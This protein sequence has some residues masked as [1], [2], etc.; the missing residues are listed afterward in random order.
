MELNP[1]GERSSIIDAVVD[2][3]GGESKGKQT[4]SKRVIEENRRIRKLHADENV[5]NT[6]R[7]I[8]EMKKVKAEKAKQKESVE[9]L[10]GAVRGCKARQKETDGEGMP[11]VET[12]D[13]P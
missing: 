2:I 11:V 3:D 8:A 1:V 6:K 10:Q 7:L 5:Q 9:R 13:S 12:S 4:A